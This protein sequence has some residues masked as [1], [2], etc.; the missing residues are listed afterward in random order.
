MNTM[1]SFRLARRR[2]ACTGLAGLLSGLLGSS[3]AA[4]VAPRDPVAKDA[5][6]T[7]E[8][9]A[10]QYVANLKRLLETSVVPNIK[11]GIL[12][13]AASRPHALTVEVTNDPSP[14]N[15][16]AKVDLDGS[17]TVRLSLGY[18]T[19]HD[20]AL[21][22]VALSGVLQRP[23]ELRR[24]LIYQ[25]HLAHENYWRRT[26]GAR[27]EHAMTFAEFVGLDLKVTQ[28]IYAQPQWLTSRNRVQ[29]D[30]LGWTVAYLLVRADSK[31]AGMSPGQT[32]RDGAG[33]AR[34]AIASD[35]FPVP[36]VATA[37]GI[38]AIEHSAAAAFD[39]R[40]LLC[41]AAGLMEAGVAGM[42]A[43][44]QWRSQV[45]QDANL[46]RRV[47]EIW[48]QIATM[49]RDGGCASGDAVAT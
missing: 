5:Q 9:A 1:E 14:Y 16:G 34:L 37:L 29:A 36:P 38:A 24:Y 44:T 10:A 25:L 19:M 43:N 15:V 21:D 31:L 13:T 35:W 48:S 4:D 8:E 12:N 23:R 41:R 42:R 18:L 28:A 49:Q 20:A 33:A 7:E 30:S 17:L 32:A 27:A 40:A 26:R 47:G 39:E 45:Q 2:L 3:M 6:P 46:Q 11:R 22:A